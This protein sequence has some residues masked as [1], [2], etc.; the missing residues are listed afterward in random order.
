MT[1]PGEVI[2]AKAGIQVLK[3]LTVVVIS[4]FGHNCCHSRAGGNPS[5]IKS[6]DPRLC[7]GDRKINFSLSSG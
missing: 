1:S 4:S 5:F 6:M 2:P 3:K 7:E